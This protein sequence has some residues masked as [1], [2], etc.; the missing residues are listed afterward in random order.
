VKKVFAFSALAAAAMTVSS[1]HAAHIIRPISEGPANFDAVLSQPAMDLSAIERVRAAGRRAQA[2]LGRTAS[3]QPQFDS[4]RGTPTFVWAGREL[5]SAA[6]GPVAS[7][8]R[9]EVAARDYLS[10]QAGIFG[11]DASA[12]DSARLR[13]VRDL[14]RGP[15][16]ARFDQVVD[17]LEVFG[18][19]LNMMMDRNLHPV[20]TSGGFATASVVAA[21]REPRSMDATSAAAQALTELG[22]RAAGRLQAGNSKD[23][24]QLITAAGKLGDISLAEP[25]RVKAVWYPTT[26][27][28][29][30]A[31]YVEVRTDGHQQR[32]YMFVISAATGKTLFRKNMVN[33]AEY[34]Y[35][36]FADS[37][38]KHV[39]YDHPLGNDL[40]PSPF[41]APDEGTVDRISADTNLITQKSS[42]YV[43]DPWLPA[44][45]TTTSGNNVM[46]YLDLVA[47]QGYTARLGDVI[48]T[49]SSD[50]TFDYPYT[51]D[52][53]PTTT[54]A[55][56]AAIVNLFYLNNF[57]HD[58]WY[59][60][61][62]DEAAGNAQ[63]DNYDRG[64]VE[65]DAINAEG[66][67]YSGRNN[68]NMSTPADGGH[69]RM[70]MYLFDGLLAGT[71]QVTDPSGMEP[72]EFAAASFGP[73]SFD[74]TGSLVAYEDDTDPTTDA[75][76]A[77][78]N[79]SA[80]AGNI[81]LIDR[82]SCNFTVK[83]GYA[84]A[85]GATAVVIAN[86]VD[87]SPATM[88]GDDTSIT[89]GSVMVSMDDGAS[90]RSLLADGSVTM[91]VERDAATDLDGT[92]D[93]QVISHEFFHYVSNRLVGNGSGLNNNQGGGMGE[94]WS[95]VSS[96]VLSA[97][98]GDDQLADNSRW[99]GPYETGAYVIGDFYYGIRRAPY[100]T[101]FAYNALTF[102]D[103]EDGVA[104]PDTSPFSF[105][106]DGSDNAEVHNTGE[107]WA[108]TVWEVFVGLMNLHGYKDGRDRLM[109]YIIAGLEM[110]PSSPTFTE[111]RDGILAAAMASSAEDYNVVATA[112][113]KRGMGVD[114]VSPDR[115][116]TTNSGVVES[117]QA[118]SPYTYTGYTLDMSYQDGSQGSCDDDNYLDAGEYGYLTLTVGSAG[119]A[120]MTD[121][122]KAKVKGSSGLSFPDG[123]KVEFV[124]AADGLSATGII[125]V[126][127]DVSFTGHSANAKVTFPLANID[128]SDDVTPATATF[129]LP[130][131]YDLK[132]KSYTD[133]VEEA[134]V[135][136][137]NWSVSGGSQ[138]TWAVAD[139]DSTL[140]SGSVWYAADASKGG[141]SFLTSGKIKVGSEPF[142]ISFD[143]LVDFP[144]DGTPTEGATLEINVDGGGWINVATFGAT[145]TPAFNGTV[146]MV[147]AGEPAWIGEGSSMSA[148]T[149]SF[150]TTLAGS[151]VKLRFVAQSAKGAEDGFGW[152]VDNFAVDGADK[153]PF[154]KMSKQKSSPCGS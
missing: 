94:G 131:N 96:L 53:V 134:E 76:T 38:G 67:D 103:I 113:A 12:V 66:Q 149:V 31:W 39:P 112:F 118:A 58:L 126:S 51:A 34:S 57:L 141:K 15:V 143:Q 47:P 68:A 43:S 106:Q 20:A 101:D 48:G 73:T 23:G 138:I 14:G 37:D 40:T 84:Q 142:S 145:V 56:S 69:P 140:G 154:Y 5:L 93:N 79:A 25:A 108:N 11:I 71:V 99:S 102:K 83:V 146:D 21:A 24:Y 152:A 62:F 109:D 80:L 100:S 114:A 52:E 32:D 139:L 148:A 41:T 90:L 124:P 151:S 70:Q 19:S 117:Y 9:A 78:V 120:P 17:G 29:I 77:P 153:A 95:D 85:A 132:K 122:F 2:S 130:I 137:A 64:G 6:V 105:G 97:R 54:T 88:G 36:V 42:G 16:I 35:R 123:N 110:T 13:N 3:A 125:P 87:G 49:V 18:R 59:V 33:S 45:A 144:Y 116:S 150:G 1:A 127:T 136:A 55:Q 92:M 65:G 115:S 8:N 50:S 63:A 119:G 30:P 121:S 89:I 44:G 135:T 107:V 111:A 72:L 61:G 147:A 75:C 26:E 82:G 91:H 129:T 128:Y 98:K 27:A 133:D 10:Q 22:G 86:N 81:A 28:L 60:H 46:A 104:L 74:V 7:V 4:R